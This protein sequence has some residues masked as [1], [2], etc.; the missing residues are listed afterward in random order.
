MA[1]SN[2]DEFP[3]NVKEALAKRSAFRCNFQPCGAYTIGPSDNSSA[4]SASVGVACHIDG[5]APNGPRRDPSMSSMD[6]RSIDNGVWMC[7]THATLIDAD[8]TQYTAVLLKQWKVEAEAFAKSMIGVQRAEFEES[9]AG[10]RLEQ[11]L[12]QLV[13]NRL[14]DG[15]TE[16]RLPLEIFVSRHS[17][18]GSRAHLQKLLNTTDQPNPKAELLREL[19]DAIC[20]PELRDKTFG[21][22]APPN[23]RWI[24]WCLNGIIL[25]AESCERTLIIYGARADTDLV[26]M[27]E[28]LYQTC[29]SLGGIIHHIEKNQAA[30][31]YGSVG[32]SYFESILTC[33][34]KAQATRN[35]AI[36]RRA[37]A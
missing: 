16:L 19:V 30:D 10:L 7:Q 34:L 28:E 37:R 29:R 17:P 32:K 36:G 35:R 5:A 4:S 22:Y 3:S 27:L 33:M 18:A 11:R 31:L 23:I 26:I 2:R 6:R 8:T 9:I 13:A 15:I 14:R 24:D 21:T 12:N 25:C 20:L 1:K